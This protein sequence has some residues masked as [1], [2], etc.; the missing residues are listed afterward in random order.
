MLY[1]RIEQELMAKIL[2]EIA[3]N[4]NLQ[5]ASEEERQRT[6]Q[7]K[8]VHV[9]PDEVSEVTEDSTSSHHDSLLGLT[10]MHICFVFIIS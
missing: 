6:V 10:V 1:C 8:H 5:L 4:R 9:E 2:S 7:E 3:Q